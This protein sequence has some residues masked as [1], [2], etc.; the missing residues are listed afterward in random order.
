MTSE[1]DPQPG[2]AVVLP[3]R[4]GDLQPDLSL[5]ISPVSQWH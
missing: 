1:H 5:V 4:R 3:V 2:E